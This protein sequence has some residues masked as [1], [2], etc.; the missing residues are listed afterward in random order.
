MNDDII[1]SSIE[2]SLNER[3]Q[4]RSGPYWSFRTITVRK[5]R[6]TAGQRATIARVLTNLMAF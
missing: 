6:T 1:L 3:C 2:L 4:T 5:P